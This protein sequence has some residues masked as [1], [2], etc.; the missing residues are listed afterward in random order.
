M[1]ACEVNFDGI[2]GPTHNYAG[3]AYGNLATMGNAGRTAHPKI[4]ALQGLTKMRKVMDLGLVQGIVPPQERPSTTALRRWGFSGTDEEVLQGAIERDPVLLAQCSAPS[5]MWTANAATVAPSA[6]TSDGR[7][8][9]SVA[10]LQTNYHRSIEARETSRLLQAIMP[11]PDVFVHHPAHLT[12]NQVGDEGAANHTRLAPEYGRRGLHM[13]VYGHVGFDPA[14]RKPKL[15]PARQ[16]YEASR[17]VARQNRLD[18]DDVIFVQ[19]CP[20]VID[21]GVFHNDVI[22]VGN[23]S[24]FICHETAYINTEQVLEQLAQKMGEGFHSIMVKENELP[25]ETA[26]ETYLFNSQIVSLS[27]GTMALLAPKSVQENAAAKAIVDQWIADDSAI[28]Q[29]HYIDLDQSMRNGPACLRLRVVLTQNELASV[30]QGCILDDESHAA[31][32]AWV[33]RWYPEEM[34][35]EDLAD[36][37]LLTRSRDA[38]D[39]LTKILSLGAIYDFQH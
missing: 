33:E 22:S 25:V 8:H 26:V 38:L 14:V 3:L 32:V 30:H 16:A 13:F 10:N 27:D 7:V 20:D 36:P 9:I 2:V 5:A 37:S 23:L 6:D 19:Q 1:T 29:A 18:V 28:T 11:D 17:A 39:E 21:R 31:L 15:F 34:L 12:S 35:P 4:A 24:T